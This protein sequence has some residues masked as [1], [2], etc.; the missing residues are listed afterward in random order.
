[1]HFTEQFRERLAKVE[2]LVGSG[3]NHAAQDEEYC[4]LSPLEDIGRSRKPSW[5]SER[6]PS[7]EALEHRLASLEAKLN[8]VPLQ[9]NSEQPEPPA[10]SRSRLAEVES[11]LQQPSGGRVVSAN[12]T[13]PLP[14]PHR[15][16]TGT[17]RLKAVEPLEAHDLISPEKRRGASMNAVPPE[18]DQVA[19][20]DCSEA[21]GSIRGSITRDSLRS[22]DG[23]GR[24]SGGLTMQWAASRDSGSLT[25]MRSLPKDG[26]LI[27][28]A[29]STSASSRSLQASGL[30]GRGSS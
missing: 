7:L 15:P 11:H 27:G 3:E 29:P 19:S 24:D 14:R 26:G 18:D 4:Q 6:Q 10:K 21:G 9:R 28:S 16:S 13:P 8:E 22:S 20:V 12:A 23:Y 17:G 1:V 5:H 2:Q 30:V 25:G